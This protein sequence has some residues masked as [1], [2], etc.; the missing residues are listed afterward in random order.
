[1]KKIFLS[2]LAAI[3]P[4]VITIYVI[5]G[6]FHFADNILGQHI[7]SYLERYLGYTIPGLG[8]ILTLLIIFLLGVLIRLSRMKFTKWIERVF[9]RIPFAHK[10]YIPVKRMMNFLFFDTNMQFRKVA[11]VEYPRK[12]IYSIGFITNDACNDVQNEIK[13][14]AYNVFL[15]SSPSPLTGFMLVVPEEELTFLTI[16]VEQAIRLIVSGGVLN[17]DEINSQVI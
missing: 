15:P 2:G 7:N 10:I 6:L 16:S 8:I 5:V 13:R 12:G 9:L 17:P 1:M 11:L 3:I 14:K 4:F